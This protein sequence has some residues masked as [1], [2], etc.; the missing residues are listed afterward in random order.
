[1][2]WHVQGL[3][4][5]FARESKLWLQLGNSFNLSEDL[6]MIFY[7]STMW[8]LLPSRWYNLHNQANTMTTGTKKEEKKKR[9]EKKQTPQMCECSDFVS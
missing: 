5:T 6:N 8:L 2:A 7:L 9:K 1:M 4:V 3:E